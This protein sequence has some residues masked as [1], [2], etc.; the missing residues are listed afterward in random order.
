MTLDRAAHT[1]AAVHPIAA[2][3]L[4]WHRVHGRHDLPWQHPRAPYPVWLSEIMLQQTQVATVRAY[5]ARFMAR[6]PTVQALAEAELDAVLALWSGLGYYHR[7]RNLHRCAQVVVTQWG[8]EFP[9][10]AAQLQTLPGIGRST[11]AAIAALCFG[12]RVAILDGNVRRVL[13]R[14]LAMGGDVRRAPAERMLWRQATD[15]LPTENLSDTMPRYTQAIMDLGATVCTPRKPDCPRCPL[16]LHCRAHALGTPEAFPT[17]A[18]RPARP[19]EALWLL[20][21]QRDDG[22]LWLQQRPDKGIW[23]RLYTLPIFPSKRLL[24]QRWQ[25][26]KTEQQEIQRTDLAVIPHALTHKQLLLHPCRVTGLNHRAPL[27]T[28]GD[29]VAADAWPDLGLPAPLR[30]LLTPGV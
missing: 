29:W 21:A 11:A 1:T 17:P 25:L 8:G 12:E 14:Y 7:A 23:A 18:P 28:P 30:K 16:R 27:P 26:L 5:F 20:W 4:D 2:A 3:L 13:A 22:A 19:T 6:F 10:R 24:E 9:R 15:F